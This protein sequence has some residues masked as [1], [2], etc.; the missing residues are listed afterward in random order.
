MASPSQYARVSARHEALAAEALERAP[1]A[2]T[3]IAP[4]K[5][6]AAYASSVLAPLMK[7]KGV[8]LSHLQRHWADIVGADLAKFC[9]P[10]KLQKKDD[11]YVLTI[12]AVGAAAPKIYAQQV[13]II[14]RVNLAGAMIKGP[15]QIKQ[16]SLTN[17]PL[18]NVRPLA[19]SLTPEEEA[20]LEA[21][22]QALSSG[23]LRDAL[24]RLGKA[25]AAR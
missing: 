5:N 22:L 21:G 24:M 6:A 12:Q 11:G 3:A 15:L 16:G 17:R 10:E 9:R 4:P 23:R 1:R 14:E 8:S 25:V 7:D 2:R 13:M 18:G 20:A 19:R